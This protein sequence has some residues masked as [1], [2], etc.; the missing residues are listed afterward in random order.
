MTATKDDNPIPT[1]RSL[2][3]RMKNWE[4]QKSWHEFFHTYRKFIYG[5]ARQSGLADAEAQDVVQETLIC[6]AK[7]MG[8]FNTSSAFGS[9]KAWLMQITRR[10]ITDQF[11]KHARR[12][13][14][15]INPATETGSTT[16]LNKIPNPSA[17]ELELIWQKEWEQSLVGLALGRVKQLVS[18]KQF[19][20][21]YQ[22]VFKQ[23]PAHKVASKY[24]VNLAQVY[25]AKYRVGAIFKREVQKLKRRLL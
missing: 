3:E 5:V 22:Q 7:K 23:W 20:F 6:V 24:S 12:T 4:D 16:F 14:L 17:S 1:R 13:N 25:M 11:R 10:R 2:L 19:L 15:A 8:D 18:S 9:F 21:F